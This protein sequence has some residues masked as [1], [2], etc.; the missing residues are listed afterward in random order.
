MGGKESDC[1]DATRV[2]ASGDQGVKA[3][4][5]RWSGGR[6]ASWFGYLGKGWE[7]QMELNVGYW[8]NPRGRLLLRGDDRTRAHGNTFSGRTWKERAEV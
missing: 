5:R 6:I 2:W 7:I 8:L 1:K 3:G 4:T